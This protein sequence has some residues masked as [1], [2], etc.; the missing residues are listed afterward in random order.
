LIVCEDLDNESDD[1]DEND[2]SLNFEER[3][4]KGKRDRIKQLRDPH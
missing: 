2:S 3:E 4:E 1:E